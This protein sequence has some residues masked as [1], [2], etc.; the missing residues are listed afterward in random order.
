[1]TLILKSSS[2][3]ITDGKN[4]GISNYGNSGLAKAGSGDSLTGIL[5]GLFAYLSNSTYNISA[6]GAYI[7]GKSA[8]ALAIKNPEET[9]T[10]T[11]I[12]KMIPKII[13]KIK[14]L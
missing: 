12:I 4:I 7:F 13:T 9:I 1:M 6:L 10:I 14:S 8:E 11:E 5:T 3:I 2:I